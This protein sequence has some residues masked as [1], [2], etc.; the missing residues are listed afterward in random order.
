MNEHGFFHLLILGLAGLKPYRFKP[1]NVAIR[2]AQKLSNRKIK[3]FPGYFKL[4]VDTISTILT[5]ILPKIS[6]I[7][8][9]DHLN[10]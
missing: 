4:A 6:F 10:H 5:L 2:Q 7:S 1:I 8:I 9:N 3:Y